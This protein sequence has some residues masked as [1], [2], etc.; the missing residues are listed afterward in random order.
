MT[1]GGAGRWCGRGAGPFSTGRSSVVDHRSA[2]CARRCPRP[3]P[4]RLS[5]PP[6]ARPMLRAVRAPDCPGES[7]RRDCRRPPAVA[8]HSS[9]FPAVRHPHT[10][11]QANPAHWPYLPKNG[12]PTLSST[13]RR[14][15]ASAHDRP[16]ENDQETG[17]T[18]RQS[19][20]FARSASVRPASVSRIASRARCG[21]AGKPASEV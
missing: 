14:I 7:P 2:S 11:V 12:L 13:D 5:M 4:R 10:L 18:N 1:A 6:A 15:E 19:A 16:E 8:R 9:P 20:A 21:A 3:Y 17:M